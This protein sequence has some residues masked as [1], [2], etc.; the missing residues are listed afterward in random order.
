MRGIIRR[1]KNAIGT[2]KVQVG[3]EKGHTSTPLRTPEHLDENEA[4]IEM[5]LSG[6]NVT[7]SG[8]YYPRS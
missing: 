5:L 6:W 1:I 3:A 7:A 4:L 2:L 8:L